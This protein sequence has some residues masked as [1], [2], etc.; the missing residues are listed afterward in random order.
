MTHECQTVTIGEIALRLGVSTRTVWRAR[1]MLGLD[2][3]RIS[4]TPRTIRYSVPLLRQH[5]A[6]WRAL[7]ITQQTQHEKTE[8]QIAVQ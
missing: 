8:G 6:W 2:R 7:E 5:E 4:L 1:K 3:A